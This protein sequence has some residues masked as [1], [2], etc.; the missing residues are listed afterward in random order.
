MLLALLAAAALAAPLERPTRARLDPAVR[1]AVDYTA[2]VV[3]PGSV[4]VGLGEIAIGV[5]P[6]VEVATSPALDAL[7]N[8]LLRAKVDAARL[9]PLDVAVEGSGQLVDA[10]GLTGTRLRGGAVASLIVHEHLSVHAGADHVVTE[11]SGVPELDRWVPDEVALPK[12]A[13]ASATTWGRA[14]VDVRINRRDSLILEGRALLWSDARSE[15]PELDLAEWLPDGVVAMLDHEGAVPVEA[16]GVATLAYQ[17]SLRNL[18]LRVGGGV[19][20]VPGAWLLQSTEIAWRFGG[21][22]R[23]EEAQAR[24]EWRTARREGVADAG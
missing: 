4:R 14:A 12:V 13:H 6:R 8:P 11:I 16:M 10:F 19:S 5:A 9:G 1:D 24:R 18:D 21:K 22:T 23:L 20:S 2:Y 7:Q 15:V 3:E 17:L